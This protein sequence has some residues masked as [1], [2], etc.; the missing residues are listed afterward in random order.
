MAKRII[1]LLIERE[2]ESASF[3][4]LRKITPTVSVVILIIFVILHVSSLLYVKI[5][6]NSYNNLKSQTENLEKQITA[7]K[8][9]EAVYITTIGVLEKIKNVLAND[10]NVI[11]NT[12]PR[13]IGFQD[14]DLTID[15]ITVD[16]N[17]PVA[18]VVNASSIEI[19]ESFVIR[20]KE[21][22]KE[23]NFSDVRA[24]NIIRESDGSYSFTV[25]LNVLAQKQ[26]EI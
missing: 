19:M 1:N 4:K 26:N 21:A 5:N 25:S 12:L 14:N 15:S 9:S 7:Q 3:S 11:R 10:S 8:S 2:P 16:N 23:Y 24:A 20:L 6:L 17:G 22:E 18:F 13:L